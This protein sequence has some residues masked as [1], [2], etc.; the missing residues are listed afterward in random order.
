MT[1]DVRMKQLGQQLIQAPFPY[2]NITIGK[3]LQDA[4][5]EAREAK[6]AQDKYVEN[7]K[8]K[9]KGG[10]IKGGLKNRVLYNKAKYKR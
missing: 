2:D 9:Q 1:E 5:K 8:K 3:D 6:A 4:A 10:Y 7:L